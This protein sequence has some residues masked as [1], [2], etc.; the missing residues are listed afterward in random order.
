VGVHATIASEYSLYASDQAAAITPL[1]NEMVKVGLWLE[2]VV[3][4][5]TAG[6]GLGS[7]GVP[8]MPTW[9]MV[10]VI[11]GGLWA[12]R[13]SELGR[14]PPATHEVVPQLL[15]RCRGDK[16]RDRPRLHFRSVPTFDDWRDSCT[17]LSMISDQVS[18]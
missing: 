11:V 18:R 16:R 15:R 1:I 13:V 17:I 2:L 4:A 8:P 12:G 7:L 5:F 3:V 9:A 14:W 10:L 6:L